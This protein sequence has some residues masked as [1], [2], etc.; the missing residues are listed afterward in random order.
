MAS[1]RAWWCVGIALIVGLSLWLLIAGD[2]ETLPPPSFTS[3]AVL[4]FESALEDVEQAHLATGLSLDLSHRLQAL[5]SLQLTAR[6][7]VLVWQEGDTPLHVLAR[8]LGAEILILGGVSQS[9]GRVLLSLEIVDARDGRQIA[10]IEIADSRER[11]FDLQRRAAIQVV[12]ALEIPVAR[13]A[14]ARLRRDPTRSL[15]AWG[16]CVQAQDYLED[17]VNPRAPAFAADLFRRAIQH[18]PDFAQ[19]H[20]GLSEA[21]WRGHIRYGEPEN[22]TEAEMEARWVLSRY[23]KLSAAAVILAKLLLTA[24]RSDASQSLHIAEVSRLAKPDEALRDIATG[25]H[26]AGKLELAESTWRAAAS[27]HGDL[28]LNPYSLGR[29]LLAGGRYNEA[30]FA[31]TK[32]VEQ[33]P[34]EM[35]WPRESLAKVKLAMGDLAGALDVFETIEPRLA[36][37]ETLRQAA[38][39]YAILGQLPASERV[40][41]QGIELDP[42]DPW[43]HQGLGD[44]LARQDRPEL[45]KAQYVEG[46]RILERELTASPSDPS[47]ELR[48]AVL[49][50]KARDCPRALPMAAT[51][52]RHLDPSAESS[53]ELAL[54]FGLCQDTPAAIDILRVALSLGLDPERVRSEPNFQQL[55]SDADF[56]AILSQAESVPPSP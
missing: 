32:A 22:L 16:Y 20:V 28:W 46:L 3:L 19:A 38:A 56:Q 27:L 36:D 13:S 53:Y 18:D 37:I 6:R 5:G 11:I 21:L 52:R 48:L 34:P 10:A 47:L 30:A 1:S 14:K 31:F 54:V 39:A 7:Q 15:K 41:R 40:Y 17:L 26:H 23:P 45:A 50:A 35:T 24:P 9:S 2:S 8:Q 44:V 49:A 51:L 42:L 43:L 12:D 55:T 33:S 4:P 25:L 29:F